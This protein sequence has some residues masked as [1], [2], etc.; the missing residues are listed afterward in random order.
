[1]FP[2]RTVRSPP[3]GFVDAKVIV[4]LVAVAV[5]VDVVMYCQFVVDPTD[6]F[7]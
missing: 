5:H 2:K 3:K 1:M 6:A 7:I 4:I